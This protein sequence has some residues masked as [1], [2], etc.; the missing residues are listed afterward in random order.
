MSF[1]S[2]YYLVEFF[3]GSRQHNLPYEHGSKKNMFPSVCMSFYN[4]THSQKLLQFRNTIVLWWQHNVKKW[5]LKH[6]FSQINSSVS[7]CTKPDAK[8]EGILTNNWLQFL[9]QLGI[10]NLWL[11]S[12]TNLVK[13][14]LSMDN[15]T[16][17]HRQTVQ[18]HL[19]FF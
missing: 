13:L 14:Y 19:L 12:V 3:R 16:M 1:S 4:K 11:L 2:L 6:V 18:Q 9:N 8:R 10:T 17:K 7:N 15:A 5:P